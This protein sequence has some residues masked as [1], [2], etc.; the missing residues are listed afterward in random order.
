[1]SR[2]RFEQSDQ[3]VAV[4]WLKVNEY[5][6][7]GCTDQYWNSFRAASD[8]ASGG[9]SRVPPLQDPRA[10]GAERFG[11]SNEAGQILALSRFET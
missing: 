10:N 5:V 9:S 6:D 7:F 8:L 3:A 11:S 1:M 4:T 2:G